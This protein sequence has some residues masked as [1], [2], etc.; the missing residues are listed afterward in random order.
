[1]SSGRITPEYILP[2]KALAVSDT[3]SQRRQKNDRVKKT[4]IK[5]E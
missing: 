3:N 5:E 2:G 1:M 4:Y